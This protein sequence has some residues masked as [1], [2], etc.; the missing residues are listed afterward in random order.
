MQTQRRLHQEPKF[1][2]CVTHSLFL[3]YFTLLNYVHFNAFFHYFWAHRKLSDSG[4]PPH[5]VCQA[6]PGHLRAVPVTQ[7]PRAQRCLSS[8]AWFC[9][10]TNVQLHKTWVTPHLE[11]VTPSHAGHAAGLRALRPGAPTPAPTALLCPNCTQLPSPLPEGQ[12]PTGSSSGWR[13]R[14]GKRAH[15]PCSHRGRGFLPQPGGRRLVSSFL[16]AGQGEQRW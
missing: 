15:L 14:C 3:T 12:G 7:S 10:P 2:K 9:F 11:C 6:I 1:E 16:C 5:A 13:L 4:S 8:W